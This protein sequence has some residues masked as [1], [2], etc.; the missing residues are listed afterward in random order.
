LN[1]KAYKN[2]KPIGYVNYENITN[3]VLIGSALPKAVQ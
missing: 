1:P 2:N 3:S